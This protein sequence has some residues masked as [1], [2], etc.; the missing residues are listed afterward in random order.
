MIKMKNKVCVCMCATLIGSHTQPWTGIIAHSTAHKCGLPGSVP[1]CKCAH[2]SNFWT[3]PW[4][5]LWTTRPKGKARNISLHIPTL[6]TRWGT[7]LSVPALTV[8]HQEQSGPQGRHLLGQPGSIFYDLLGSH[9]R[10]PQHCHFKTATYLSSSL[11]SQETQ[12][13]FQTALPLAQLRS[14]CFSVSQTL[15]C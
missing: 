8:P 2:L 7:I 1:E 3:L 15:S 5:I 14:D 12:S 11:T 10:K 13:T 4:M 9:R 6:N